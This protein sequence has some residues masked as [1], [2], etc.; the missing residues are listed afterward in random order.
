MTEKVYLVKCGYN[1]SKKFKPY[2]LFQTQ[3]SQYQQ[4]YLLVRMNKYISCLLCNNTSSLCKQTKNFDLHK[5][6]HALIIYQL[7]LHRNILYKLQNTID[8]KAF[9]KK[10]QNIRRFVCYLD[11]HHCD[12]LQLPAE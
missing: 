3:T 5:Y 12:I 6:K 1:C 11:I 10:L 4:S 9:L 2:R 8:T 7:Y